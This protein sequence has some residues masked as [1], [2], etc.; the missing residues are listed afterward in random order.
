MV[1]YLYKIQGKQ[2]TIHKLYTN[3]FD[4]PLNVG[5]LLAAMIGFSLIYIPLTWYFERIWPGDYGVP[6]P[7]YFP[8]KVILIYDLKSYLYEIKLIFNNRSHRIGTENIKKCSMKE[9]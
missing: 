4:D 5:A 9:K 3:I 1:F 6:L 2:F 7:F 8:F